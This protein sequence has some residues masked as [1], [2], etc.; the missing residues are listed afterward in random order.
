MSSSPASHRKIIL[1]GIDCPSAAKADP[2]HK[3]AGEVSALLG[4]YTDLVECVTDGIFLDV[5][6]NKFD[7]PFGS[8]IAKMIKGEIKQRLHLQ[9]SLG[10]GP[11]K[12]LARL[13]M[14]QQRP[15][16]LVIVLPENVESFLA[17]L[18]IEQLPGAGSVTRQGL[19]EMGIE[20]IG[21]LSKTPLK[22]LVDRFGQRGKDLWLLSQGRDDEQVAPLELSSQLVEENSFA[23]PIY[24]REE[25]LDALREMTTALSGRLKRRSLRG[26]LVTLCA[27]Y[28][29]QRHVIRKERL[30]DFTDRSH[31]LRETVTELLDHTEAF[32]IGVRQLKISLAGFTGEAVEQLDL[33]DPARTTKDQPA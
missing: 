11:T 25:I 14:R 21:Q 5:T 13:A 2:Q 29:D 6:Y 22:P 3:I 30:A 20:R 24:E 10:M 26:R 15:D 27:V 1:V 16:G 28:P 9:V 17:D 4:E 7:I 8:R 19:A 23:A 18:P 33:F 31:D 12:F 32:N